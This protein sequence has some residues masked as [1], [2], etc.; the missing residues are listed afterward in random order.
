[1]RWQGRRQS[2]NVEDQRGEG[3]GFP[4]GI[5][6]GGGFRLPGGSGFRTARGGGFSGIV[7][8]AAIFL[9]LKFCTSIDPMQ[10]LVGEDGGQLAPGQSQAP[11][12][13]TSVKN[14]DQMTQFA[15]TVLAETEDVWS[16]IFQAEGQTISGSDHGVVQW[17]SPLRLWLCKRC[18][19]DHSTA[20]ATR[21]SIST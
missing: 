16:G 6:R 12:S 17:P 18:V 3:G 19:R 4:G 9:F 14:D 10:I 1:M 21:S 13:G 5:G 20:P 7:I 11:S 8:L 15:R 2:D